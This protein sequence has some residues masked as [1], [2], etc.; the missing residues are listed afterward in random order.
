MRR[1]VW[2]RLA[3]VCAAMGVIALWTR[4]PASAQ[5]RPAAGPD[6]FR[7]PTTG[8]LA[9]RVIDAAIADPKTWNVLIANETSSTVPLGYVFDGLVGRN[10][11]TL[12]IEP[13]LASSWQES[14]DHLKWTFKLR[15]GTQWSDGQP[16]T[17]D[18]VVFTFNLIYDKNIPTPVR[19]ILTFSGKPMKYRKVDPMT[20]EFT[21]P[22]V[23]GPFLDV[24]GP[25][26]LPK[27]KLEAAWR[28]GQF[29]N[30]WNLSTPVTDIVGTGPFII[31]KYTPSQNITFRRNP[32]YW[33]AG[34]TG[35][36]LP[37]LQ[38]LFTE[39][40]PD[41]NTTVLRFR[42][43]ETDYVQ[44]RPQDWPS[45][46]AGAG[47]GGYRALD[48]G[49][50]W[51]FSYLSFNV[52]PA[53]TKLP[54]YKRAWFNSK[55]F[56]QA[57]SYAIDRQNMCNTAL[58]G[59]GRPLFSPVSVANKLY[60]DEKLKPIPHDLAKAAALLGQAHFVKRGADLYDA[61]GHPVEFT[62]MTNTG[63]NINAAYCTAIQEELRK[64][65]IKVTVSQV[66]FNSL[67][68]RLRKTFDWEAH[69]LAFTGGVEQVGGKN[70]WLSSGIVHPWWPREAKPATPW[71][72][73]IDRIFGAAEKEPDSAKR[74]TLY[75]KWQEI[76]Y[77]QQPLIFLTTSDSL[78]AVKNNLAN[79]RPNSLGGVRWNIY[80]FS[81]R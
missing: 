58:R 54:A 34:A 45:V 78:W 20:V 47:S 74:K 66:E 31:S 63:N 14:K 21:L 44:L 59:L 30:T 13:N 3:A 22:T 65:G 60:F 79:V 15:R 41:L 46:R 50:N 67:V 57:I 23:V 7:M 75:N 38:G 19:D 80:E 76:L 68:E 28:A 26:I 11:E 10:A 24:I 33:R 18:D 8:K 62:L 42:A 61:A 81:E 32:L 36:R 49:P 70:V 55:Q 16:F 69:V 1:A 27:H 5:A 35:A 64:L 12:K 53:N 43:R 52:N 25:A 4:M 48:V 77:D 40:V 73:E 72:A 29:N 37:Y 56:R 51:G 17:A 39:V 2:I 6:L 71:E 9:G